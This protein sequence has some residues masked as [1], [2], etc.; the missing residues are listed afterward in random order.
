MSMGSLLSLVVDLTR[1]PHRERLKYTCRPNWSLW[2]K[3]FE[4]TSSR[5]FLRGIDSLKYSFFFLLHFLREYGTVQEGA[6]SNYINPK[7]ILWLKAFDEPKKLL[8]G[9]DSFKYS[10]SFFLPFAYLSWVWYDAGAL[11][12]YHQATEILPIAQALGN[13][14]KLTI[15]GLNRIKIIAKINKKE[16]EYINRKGTSS[17]TRLMRNSF[18]GNTSTTSTSR[19]QDRLE[20][21]GNKQKITIRNK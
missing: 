7:E 5:N 13:G 9:I 11:S 2:L 19:K 6:L 8:L 17:I 16:R 1:V 14:K 18:H 21:R 10:F 15:R 3:A 12:N 20:I 4:D